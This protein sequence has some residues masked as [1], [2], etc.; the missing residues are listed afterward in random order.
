MLINGVPCLFYSL[1]NGPITGLNSFPRIR[2]NM[3]FLFALALLLSLAGCSAPSQGSSLSASNALVW[4]SIGDAKTLNPLLSS[5]SAS[6]DVIGLVFDGLIGVNPKTLEPY[7]RLAESWNVSEDGLTY[8]FTLRPGLRFQDGGLFSSAD[9]KFTFDR[10]LDPA[11]DSPYKDAVQYLER[12]EAPDAST[13][14][15]HLSKPDCS[16][17]LTT[18]FGVLPRHLLEGRNINTAAFNSHPVGSGPFRFSEWKPDELIRVS[19][20]DGFFS[21]KPYLDEII[22]KVVPDNLVI[23]E[24]LITGEID[25]AGIEPEQVPRFRQNKN[26][27]V[28]VYSTNNYTFMGFNLLHPFFRDQRVRKAFSHA[29]DLEALTE[30][31]MLGYGET[32]N[33]P[34]SPVSWA[35]NPDVKPPAFN[36]DLAL[37]LLREA[38]FADSDGDGVLDKEG[39]PFSFELLTN[40]GNKQREKAA[41]IIQYYLKKIGVQARVS[42]LEWPTFLDQVNRKR[43]DA[44]ILGWSLGLDPD[45]SGIWHSKKA[46]KY[47]FVSYA[48]PEVDQVLDEALIVPGC[49]EE[50]RKPLYWRFQELI[51][52]DQPYVFLFYGSSTVGVN[53]RFTADDGILASP[54]GLLWNIERWK[55][56]PEYAE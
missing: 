10:L 29:I 6:S 33:G 13:V 19:A 40:K 48:N 50:K 37:G 7:P 44:V 14:V 46:G 24:Q 27:D 31:T 38:G 15:F 16:F 11:T 2:M 22:Y 54:L 28:Y 49:A 35:F 43:F 20:F 3:R 42:V 18:G 52:E 5:D 53:K 4:G 34:L 39:K 12:V 47:N 51:A 30:S 55:L 21:G 9:V 1:W 25:L 36:P 17:L 45:A 56:K 23:Q 8:T 32:A 41:V 26:L